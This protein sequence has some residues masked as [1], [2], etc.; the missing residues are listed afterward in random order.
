MTDFI[1]TIAIITTLLFS[2][3]QWKKTRE[4]IKT[5]NYSRMVSTLNDIRRE[6]LL[7]P[8]L[9]R[10]L[11]ESRKDWDDTKIRKRIY[12]VMLANILELSV[13]SHKS[14]LIDDKHWEDWM[15]TWKE[16][17]LSDKSFAELMS[18][19]TILYRH[20][21]AHEIVINFIK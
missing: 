19:K 7:M 15:T 20:F 17:I 4:T 9:E 12:G 6:R 21:E 3:W 18:D 8:D 16:V 11:F 1:Q 5:D 14:G 2:I 10:A 13:F